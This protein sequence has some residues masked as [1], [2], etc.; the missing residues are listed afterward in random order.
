MSGA[1][2]D[3]PLVGTHA[4]DAG[5][6]RPQLTASERLAASR[7]QLRLAML[8]SR[9]V[10]RRLRGASGGD[11]RTPADAD[12]ATGAASSSEAAA[13]LD[14]RARLLGVP[15]IALLIDVVETWWARHPM[16]TAA[17]VAGEASTALV[18]PMAQRNP[19]RLVLVAFVVGAIL[20]KA[21]PWRW[22]LRRTLFAGL[23]P[24]IA[25]RVAAEL[26]VQK[27]LAKINRP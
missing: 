6:P 27:W 1:V 13:E 16:R 22:M 15:G 24:Q 25:L 12:D 21:R 18:R 5:E 7:E 8:P 11:G 3:Q 20:S 9:P 26:P 14:W 2:P 19:L 23:L 4:A 10:T 17:I